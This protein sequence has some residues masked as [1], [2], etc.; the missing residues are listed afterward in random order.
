MWTDVG[1]KIRSMELC[2]DDEPTP[3]L[4]PFNTFCKNLAVFW[5]P[6]HHL[7]SFSDASFFAKVLRDPAEHDLSQLLRCK[8]SMW[9]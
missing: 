1:D 8:S 7:P 9:S 4:S 2:F 6:F 5:L 3:Q